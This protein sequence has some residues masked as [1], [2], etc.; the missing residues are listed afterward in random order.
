MELKY[1]NGLAGLKSYHNYVPKGLTLNQ[2]EQLEITYNNGNH[3]PLAL[4]EY[5]FVAGGD[6]PV[7]EI[8][9]SNLD[10]LQQRVRGYLV[11]YSQQINRPFFAFENWNGC[12]YFLFV[13]GDDTAEDPIIWTAYLEPDDRTPNFLSTY[14]TTLTEY[15]N[16]KVSWVKRGLSPF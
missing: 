10:E 15:V 7:V 3:F 1:M 16:E 12:E 11:E 6:S 8:N 4:R 5:L 9:A 13:Y 2:I 14:G